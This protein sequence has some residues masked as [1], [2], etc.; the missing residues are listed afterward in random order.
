MTKCP[1]DC[2]GCS[3]SQSILKEETESGKDELFCLNKKMIV[4]EN[5]YCNNYN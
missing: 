1:E 4:N 2:L 3:D 5:G